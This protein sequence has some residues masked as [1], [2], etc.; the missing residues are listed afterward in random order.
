MILLKS[1]TFKIF[2]VKEPQPLLAFECRVTALI[3]FCLFINILKHQYFKI[4]A[5]KI[6]TFV[7]LYQLP[8]CPYCPFQVKRTFSSLESDS[9]KYNTFQTSWKYYSADTKEY[10]SI[11]LAVS[12]GTYE[13]KNQLSSRFR[14]SSSRNILSK[15]LSSKD[16]FV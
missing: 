6:V 9:L 7:H 4:P 14:D 8:P 12:K 10:Y 11:L 3:Y 15:L 2:F 16:M 5:T 13:I 1:Q